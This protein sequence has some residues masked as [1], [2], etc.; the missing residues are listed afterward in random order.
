GTG[1]IDEALRLERRVASAQGNPGANDPRRW[2]RLL[3][4]ARLARLI[5]SPPKTGARPESVKRE[6]KELGLF[7]GPGRLVLL[8]WE[9]L[10]ASLALSAAENADVPPGEP[11]DAAKVGLYSLTMPR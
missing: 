5:H 3:S 11:T 4:A 6:L 8:T 9:D 2:A 7:S 10:D 1:R